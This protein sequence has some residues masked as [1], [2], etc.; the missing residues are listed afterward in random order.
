LFNAFRLASGIVLL[1]LL[2]RVLSRA[3]LG[4]Y[5]V[6]LELGAIAYLADFGFSLSVERSVAYAVGGARGLSA[7]GV[8][9]GEAGK[10]PNEALLAEILRASRRLYRWLAL[11]AAVVLALGGSIVVG[12]GID[13]AE[14]RPSVIWLAWA[15]HLVATS[16]EIYSLFWV[17]ALRG[18]NA[19]TPSARWLSIA[20]GLK[21]ALSAVF[22]LAGFGLLSV[23][24]AGL[25]SGIVLRAG[26]AREVF[27]RTRFD[28][29]P[30]PGETRR[31]LSALWPNSWRLGAQL[32][33]VFATNSAFASICMAVDRLGPEAYQAYGLSMQV[34]RI[35]LGIAAVWT[36]VKWPVV[37]Q[38]RA[39]GEREAI[40]AVLAP[41]FRLHLATFLFLAFCAV[42]AGPRLLA[43]LDTDKELLALPLLALLAVNALGELNFAF[44]TTL[45]STENRIPSTW[46][47]VITQGLALTAAL[48]LVFG[49]GWGL[50]A[51]VVSPL[52]LGWAFNYWWWAREGARMLG[53]TF[54][55]FLAGRTS[56]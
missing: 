43:L 21:L 8:V 44:W 55:R 23:P 7:K 30:A 36:S 49:L 37:A 18:L 11:G 3:E 32:G 33:A 38:H 22:L 4:L 29:P 54:P 47:L 27:K 25:I 17:A 24:V 13:Q 45:I 20:Y 2:I 35:T 56:S 52:V 10:G 41:R 16:L 1:P 15:I 34:M 42:V 50:A 46:P 28:S 51:F 19:V 12:L 40:V 39:R 26:A 9:P 6:F 48:I 31:I 5:Y 53:T 14:S